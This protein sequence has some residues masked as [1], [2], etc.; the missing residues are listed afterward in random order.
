MI[1]LGL[2]WCSGGCV[3]GVRLGFQGGI[4]NAISA[5]IETIVG[6]ALA[7]ITETE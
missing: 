4:E 2:A 1:L 6:N 7:P 3:D 5:A